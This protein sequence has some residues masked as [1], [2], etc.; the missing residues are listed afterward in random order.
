MIINLNKNDF[1]MLAITKSGNAMVD[2]LGQSVLL[3]REH[4][5]KV[6][7]GGVVEVILD[8]ITVGE[9]KTVVLCFK[10]LKF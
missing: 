4:F 7:N 5:N 8:S 10:T 1:R 3:K 9:A 2:Y 6:L